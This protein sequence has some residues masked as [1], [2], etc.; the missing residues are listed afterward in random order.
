MKR[1]LLIIC[2]LP[3]L[4]F[5]QFSGAKKLLL[6]QGECG[7]NLSEYITQVPFAYAYSN[8]AC[9]ISLT[10]VTDLTTIRQ[11]IDLLRTCNNGGFNGFLVYAGYVKSRTL[12]FTVLRSNSEYTYPLCE[13]FPVSNFWGFE[14]NR[15]IG[16]SNIF[17]I[18]NGIMTYIENY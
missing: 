2:L 12:N 17:H 1:L 10:Y 9:S 14:Y 4:A 8:T 7:Y 13:L 16:Q 6:Q 5:G 3:V 15:I 18:E 11:G